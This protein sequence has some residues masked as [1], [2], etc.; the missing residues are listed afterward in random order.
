MKFLEVV[1]S[2]IRRASMIWE[3]KVRNWEDCCVVGTPEIT[4]VATLH[5]DVC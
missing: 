5:A 4:T 2:G 1:A 3:W